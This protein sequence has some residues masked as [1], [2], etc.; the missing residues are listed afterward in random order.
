MAE[1]YIELKNL[2]KRFGEL[3]AVK[4]LN[5]SVSHGTF[6][7]LIGPSGC[8]KTTTL[9]MLAGFEIPSEGH[10]VI[11]NEDI[12]LIPPNKRNISMVFQHFALFPHMNVLKNIEYGLKMRKIPEHERKQRVQRVLELLEIENLRDELVPRL[13]GG[14]QQKVGLA[15]ALVTEPKTLLLDEPMG[16]IDEALRL[17]MQRELRRLF[18]RLNITFIHVTHSQLEAFS[19][20]NRVIVMNEGSIVQDGSPEDIFRAPENDFVATFVGRNNLF[21]GNVISSKQRKAEIETSLGVFSIETDRQIPAVNEKSAFS[22][23][24]DLISINRERNHEAKNSVE[25][26]ISFMEEIENIR[27]YHISVPKD[28][29]IKVEQ[30]GFEGSETFIPSI[31]EKVWLS[32]RPEDAVLLECIM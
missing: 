17:K 10:I 5:F 29:P 27:V 7:S 3:E 28:K 6:L 8:G 21:Y 14:Q 13:S 23:R 9:R 11:D 15:R 32:W 16:S 18:E 19:M 2:T 24:S 20:A 25:A 1:S 4:D 22:I 31:G 12:S 26:G 30:H